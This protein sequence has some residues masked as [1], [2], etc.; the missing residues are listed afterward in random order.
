MTPTVDSEL[1]PGARNAVRVCL[2]IQPAERVTLISD[3]ACADIAASLMHE[4]EAVGA[5]YRSFVLEDVAERPLT[6]RR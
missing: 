1:L 4:I 5:P 3:R 6:G 2:N